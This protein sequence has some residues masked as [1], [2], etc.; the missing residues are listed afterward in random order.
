M[1]LDRVWISVLFKPQMWHILAQFSRNLAEVQKQA[2]QV[3]Y[4]PHDEFTE[5]E[6][7]DKKD[8]AMPKKEKKKHLLFY[9]CW[10]TE[11]YDKPKTIGFH[12]WQ[13]LICAQLKP[14]Q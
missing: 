5:E 13:V 3:L 14:N 1:S 6:E 2:G 8:G 11:R 7:R 12:L 4:T 10:W 9:K